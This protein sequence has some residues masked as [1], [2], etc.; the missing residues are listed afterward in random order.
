M[1]LKELID[2]Y[3][4]TASTTFLQLATCQ[5]D[6]ANGHL[7]V[8]TMGEIHPD[9]WATVITVF[10]LPCNDYHFD[11]LILPDGIHVIHLDF[12]Q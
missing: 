2:N 8:T 10:P 7:V 1:G 4:V 5:A 11:C 12:N 9:D 3:D 6:Y